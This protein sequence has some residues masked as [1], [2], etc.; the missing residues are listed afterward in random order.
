MAVRTDKYDGVHFQVTLMNMRDGSVQGHGAGCA[1][2]KRGKAKFAEPMQAT[3]VWDV[4]TK[5]DAWLSYN[6]DFLAEG[7]ESNAYEI[8][9]LP[10]AK[11]IE[12]GDTHAVYV[13]A[14][15]SS[16][17]EPVTPYADPEHARRNFS[18]LAARAGTE[19]G[20]NF[21]QAKADAI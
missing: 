16:D 21:W 2:L 8:D 6:S 12:E 7:G 10:C 9:W 20:R 15:E 3:E 14:F 5:A 19:Q 11:H 4:V 1:D 13:E 17:T 18:D